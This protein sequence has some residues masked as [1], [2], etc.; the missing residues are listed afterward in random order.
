MFFNFL[1]LVYI[2]IYLPY[3]LLTGR[4]YKG[5]G[6][7]LGFF[8]LDLKSRLGGTKSAIWI[9]A[10]SVGEIM[11]IIPLVAKLKV[12]Y[13]KDRIVVT[14]TTKTGYELAQSKLSQSAIIIPSPLDFTWVVSSFVRLIKPRIYI[15]AETEIWPNLFDR[16]YKQEIPI[17][18]MN[19]R[20]SD[21]SFG[22]YKAIGFLLKETLKKVSLF[23]MQSEK[24]TN[25]IIELGAPQE[26]VVTVGNVKFDQLSSIQDKDLKLSI[27]GNRLLWIAGSTHPGEEEII[28]KVLQEYK[29]ACSL[30]IAPR[31][32]ERSEQIIDLVQSQGLK[33]L[34]FSQ[35]SS[36]AISSD[37]V[38][39][40]DTIGHLRSLYSKAS[41]VFVGK[42]LCG[43][44]GQNIIEPA[45][46]AKPII[47]GPRMDNFRDITALFKSQEAIIQ[48]KNAEE[49]EAQVG[50]LM[51]D[52][53][54]RKQLGDKA[55]GVVQANQGALERTLK[56]L[57]KWL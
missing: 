57:Q 42:S 20:I 54:L 35:I 40:L 27:D 21:V 25:R 32:V 55:F 45:F 7:R 56:L 48:V 36:D 12:R 18:I 29:D 6:C 37:C 3:L 33:A 15:V 39:V 31:H 19:G 8:P 9:H 41:F 1:F 16:L 23:C 24:D 5:Y 4:W 17:V 47:V 49:F 51:K 38:I 44:G 2:L 11:A 13:P 28:L 22:R 50:R 53:D 46:Y 34:R 14:V 10:V 30:I 26:K 52:Q 43:G